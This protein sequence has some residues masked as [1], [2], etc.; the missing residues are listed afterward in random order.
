[1]TTK[2]DCREFGFYLTSDKGER[3]GSKRKFATYDE[4][5]EEACRCSAFC[6]VELCRSGGVQDIVILG[7]ENLGDAKHAY[8]EVMT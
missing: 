7:Y 6:A 4:C 1:M 8:R 3:L 5:A 2:Q